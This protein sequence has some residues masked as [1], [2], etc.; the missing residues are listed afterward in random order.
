MVVVETPRGGPPTVFASTV[1][2]DRLVRADGG[3]LVAHRQVIR[4]DLR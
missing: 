2:Q 1:M 4:D 3:W